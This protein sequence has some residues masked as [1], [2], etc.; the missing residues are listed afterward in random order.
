MSEKP[1]IDGLTAYELVEKLPQ[2]VLTVRRR[3]AYDQ[4]ISEAKNGRVVK[5]TFSSEKIATSR[6]L[7]I[8]NRIKTDKTIIARKTGKEVYVFPKKLIEKKTST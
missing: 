7:A 2:E 1:D 5:L 8:R 3:S 4:P 6:Y